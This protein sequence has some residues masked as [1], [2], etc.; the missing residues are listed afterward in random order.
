MKI[1]ESRFFDDANENA[2][3]TANLVDFVKSQ[4]HEYFMKK[5]MVK[6][7][8]KKFVDNR[9]HLCFY[10]ISSSQSRHFI[11]FFIIPRLKNFDISTLKALS[12]V[13]NI[14]PIVSKCDALTKD[15]LTSFKLL[16]FL[17]LKFDF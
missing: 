13:V 1:S 11:Y 6:R 10:L 3:T 7:S 17:F 5:Q 14:I 12:D 9:I 4:L 15:E 16:V 8:T 2:Q